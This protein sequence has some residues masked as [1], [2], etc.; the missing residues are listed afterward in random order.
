M[1]DIIEKINDLPKELVDTIKEYIPKHILAFTNKTNY[2]LYHKFIRPTISMYENYIRDA[3]RRDNLFVFE[4][5]AKE[6]INKW[7][8]N[9]NYNYK[10]YCFQ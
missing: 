1:N 8:S 6:N 3:I 10:K 4:F 2:I 7:V 9:K 5:I